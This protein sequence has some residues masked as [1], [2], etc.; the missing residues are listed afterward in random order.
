MEFI[1]YCNTNPL[2]AFA[3]AKSAAKFDFVCK[4]IFLYKFLKSL[5]NIA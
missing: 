1:V 2:L 3:K 5:Y 4:I